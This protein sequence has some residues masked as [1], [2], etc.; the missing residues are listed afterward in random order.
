MEKRFE[1]GLGCFRDRTGPKS[2]KAVHLVLDDLNTHF[3][4]SF[5]EVMSPHRKTSL[6][7]SSIATQDF[8]SASGL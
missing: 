6:N 3:R 5:E 4:S 1:G 7:R 2:H 8:L